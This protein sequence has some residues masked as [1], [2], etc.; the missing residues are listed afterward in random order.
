MLRSSLLLCLFVH[1]VL[2][3]EVTRNATSASNEIPSGGGPSWITPS[4]S[5]PAETDVPLLTESGVRTRTLR[6]LN[7]GF[8]SS[9]IPGTA[10]VLFINNNFSDGSTINGLKLT[11]SAFFD[12]VP[13][14]RYQFE[15][16]MHQGSN[17]LGPL[18]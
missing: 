3:A 9:D 7:F 8:T 4:A 17:I 18:R 16:K 2:C 5:L 14:A 12:P 13:G 1:Y 6:V 10:Y 15:V 11:I